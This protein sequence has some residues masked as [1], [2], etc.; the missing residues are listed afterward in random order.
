MTTTSNLDERAA[1]CGETENRRNMSKAAL[2]HNIQ[3]PQFS[4]IAELVWGE[5]V[6]VLPNMD[7]YATAQAMARKSKSKVV[8]SVVE[9]GTAGGETIYSV[10][11]VNITVG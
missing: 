10:G 1:A 6:A 11:G 7:V 8:I 9:A 4:R 2:W 3:V 5:Q